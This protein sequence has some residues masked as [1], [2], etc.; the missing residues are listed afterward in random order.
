MRH[1]VAKQAA[2]RNELFWVIGEHG[3]DE[4]IKIAIQP[5]PWYEPLETMVTRLR[6]EDKR[7][8]RKSPSGGFWILDLEALKQAFPDVSSVEWLQGQVHLDEELESTE[9]MPALNLYTFVITPDMDALRE[10]NF[11]IRPS[12]EH[13]FGLR[14]S[15]INE[16]ALLGFYDKLVLDSHPRQAA[17]WPVLS[18]YSCRIG[19]FGDWVIVVLRHTGDPGK[20]DGSLVG[21]FT[22]EIIGND[23][24]DSTNL[25]SVRRRIEQHYGLSMKDAV[26]LLKQGLSINPELMLMLQRH[27]TAM[28][29]RQMKIFLSHKWAD[30]DR[31][32]RFHRVLKQLGFEPWLDEED[33]LAGTNLQRGL[34]K[35]FE[36]SCA[37]VFFIT[38]NF[39]D[40]AYLATE[41]DYAIRQEIQRGAEQFKIVTIVFGERVCVPDLLASRI[42]YKS[43]EHDLD[44]LYEIIRGL[45]VKV[46]PVSW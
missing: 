20:R 12:D 28:G 29:L 38:E 5:S 31:V 14:F 30:N 19:T 7:W 17:F 10:E 2:G 25:H 27:E 41:I 32:R 6:E 18:G 26:L 16:R 8:I 13:F 35:G 46:G 44:A 43:C 21:T 3:Q 45:P 39:K 23:V 24:I 42:V 4:G 40:E 22:P 34:L 11:K 37:C 36:E 15:P 33:M 1:Y 9:G